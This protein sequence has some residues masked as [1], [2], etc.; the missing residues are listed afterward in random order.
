MGIILA[1]VAGGG[2]SGTAELNSE[3]IDLST[4]DILELNS[5][6]IELVAA[7]GLNKVIVPV[8]VAGQYLA[9]DTPFATTPGIRVQLGTEGLGD[10]QYGL[11]TLVSRI[12]SPTVALDLLAES[13]VANQPLTIAADTEILPTGGVLAIS[14]NDGG[15]L[16]IVGDTDL[17]FQGSGVVTATDQGL[18]QF[19]VDFGVLPSITK[20]VV[21]GG[22]N[23]GSYT[24]DTVVDTANPAVIQVNEAIPNPHDGDCNVYVGSATIIVDAVTNPAHPITNVIVGTARNITGLASGNDG[25]IGTV[26]Q[27]TKTFTLPGSGGSAADLNH[28]GLPFIVTGSTGNDGTYTIASATNNAG[29]L[30]IVVVEAIPDA[31]A[32]G[33]GEWYYYFRI[34][35]DHVTELNVPLALIFIQGST[36]NDSSYVIASAILSGGNTY[37]NVAESIPDPTVDG[38]LQLSDIIV[39]AGDQT[40]VFI[41]SSV[42]VVFRN[43]VTNDTLDCSVSVFASGSTKIYLAGFDTFSRTFTATTLRFR[44]RSPISPLMRQDMSIRLPGIIL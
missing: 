1:G 35:G 39:V 36:G 2:G 8:S 15:T 6:S 42:V 5:T 25:A 31:T 29:D 10:S 37:V 22:D 17:L 38:A 14:V 7:P 18:K 44:M 24:V 21:I 3:T 23:R 32:D 16:N 26:N 12:N 40:A 41:P 43:T 4:Q 28:A 30:E 33:L 27:G 9:G 13:I 19:T 11:D 20:L 34:A